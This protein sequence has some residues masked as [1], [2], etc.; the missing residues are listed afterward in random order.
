MKNYINSLTIRF[1]K[2]HINGNLV[3][4]RDARWFFR[5]MLIML[6]AS[7]IAWFLA[8]KD[9]PVWRLALFL[10]V[11]LAAY[12]FLKYF[13]HVAILFNRGQ[14]QIEVF[15]DADLE[16]LRCAY[17]IDQMGRITIRKHRGRRGSAH[18]FSIILHFKG[19]PEESGREMPVV[20]DES[21]AESIARIIGRFARV[22]VFDRDGDQIWPAVEEDEEEE[23]QPG[24]E[25]Q[26]IQ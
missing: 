9:I 22:P 4:Y 14:R 6:A 16:S 24:E 2:K 25:E 23:D 1:H 11:G 8:P 19:E 12:F 21:E 26:E 7:P 3:L 10:L 5:L 17:L 20:L 15:N 18:S 13:F